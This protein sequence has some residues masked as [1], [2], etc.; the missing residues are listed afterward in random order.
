LERER[1]REEENIVMMKVKD[2]MVERFRST[3]IK[4]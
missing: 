3:S 4:M 1:E 2:Q